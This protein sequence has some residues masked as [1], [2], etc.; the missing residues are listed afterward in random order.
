MKLD[1]LTNATVVN[2]AIRFVA[3]HN[4]NNN[5]SNNGKEVKTI[6]NRHLPD[7]HYID[8]YAMRNG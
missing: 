6:I 1:L 2:D 4:N 7:L 8:M 3:S 5:N